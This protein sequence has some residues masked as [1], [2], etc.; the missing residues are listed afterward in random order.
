MFRYMYKA[1][2]EFELGSGTSEGEVQAESLSIATTMLES[3]L[4][5]SYNITKEDIKAIE[6]NEA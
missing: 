2:F 5:E 3:E 4:C 6:L 1:E